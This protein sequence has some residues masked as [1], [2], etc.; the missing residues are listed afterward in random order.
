MNTES[1]N[2]GVSAGSVIT[3]NIILKCCTPLENVAHHWDIVYF[4]SSGGELYLERG[5]FSSI[6]VIGS[7]RDRNLVS[8]RRA[9]ELTTD[10]LVGFNLFWEWRIQNCPGNKLYNSTYP[11]S[12]LVTLKRA[13]FSL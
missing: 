13:F 8:R 5:S 1:L 7:D 9:T 3:L 10:L 6:S 4:L 11:L 2:K 12:R